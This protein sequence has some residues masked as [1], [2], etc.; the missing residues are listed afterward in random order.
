MREMIKKR[1]EKVDFIIDDGKYK[2]ENVDSQHI[3]VWNGKY[4]GGDAMFNPLG[5]VNDGLFELVYY[6]NL[7][8]TKRM[9]GIFDEAKNGGT[10]MYD[11]N[12]ECYRAKNLKIVNKSKN[13]NT[14]SAEEFSI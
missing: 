13:Q 4:G 11:N 1:Q 14:N 9:I 10:Q 8:G 5:I 2:I 3:T 7:I 6:Q 12:F